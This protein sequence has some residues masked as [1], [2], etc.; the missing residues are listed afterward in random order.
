MKHPDYG[1]CGGQDRHQERHDLRPH[2]AKI[3]QRHIDIC[4]VVV[5]VRPDIMHMCAVQSRTITMVTSVQMQTADLH[6]QHGSAGK[7]ND[8]QGRK[9]HRIEYTGQAPEC[10]IQ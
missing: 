7:G 4:G 2:D 3:N 1:E 8:G 9:S 10:T 5:S 6:Q